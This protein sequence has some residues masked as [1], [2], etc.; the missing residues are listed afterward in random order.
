MFYSPSYAVAPA[1]ASRNPDDSIAFWMTGCRWAMWFFVLAKDS[2]HGAVRLLKVAGDLQ[3]AALSCALAGTACMSHL[4]AAFVR[5]VPGAVK[6][7]AH[8]H[9]DFL[10]VFSCGRLG[11]SAH[12]QSLHSAMAA[13]GRQ[14]RGEPQGELG[15]A[16]VH[17]RHLVAQRIRGQ[18]GVVRRGARRTQEGS[19]VLGFGCTMHMS[20]PK[21]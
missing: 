19:R 18:E 15:D 20:F 8:T 10:I 7:V 11:T 6:L 21:Q 4:S 16:Q 14:I 13:A 3:A 17:G 9:V 1:I 5:H 2:V 12:A